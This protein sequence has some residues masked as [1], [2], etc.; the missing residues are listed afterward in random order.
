MVEKDKSIRFAF[1]PD[2][3][4]FVHVRVVGEQHDLELPVRELD[5]AQDG[6]AAI[7]QP[8]VVV[9][10]DLPKHHN[11]TSST[12]GRCFFSAA[13]ASSKLSNKPAVDPG[14]QSP[15]SSFR[16]SYQFWY[17]SF[18]TLTMKHNASLPRNLLQIFRR[19]I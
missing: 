2:S 4:Y 15:K 18:G 3:V 10:L 5:C 11:S 12:I 7:R 19:N 9:F 13:T 16:T 1:A 17:R 6:L 14:Y 8:D